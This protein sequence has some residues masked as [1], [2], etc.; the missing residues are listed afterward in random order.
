MKKVFSIV[1]ACI[2]PF[3]CIIPFSAFAAASTE[4]DADFTLEEFESLEHTYDDGIQLYA[5]G[6]I[7]DHSL[8]IAKSG[9][10]LLITGLTKGTS[11][12]KKAGFTK[13][14]IERKKVSESS[15]S[16]YKTYSDLYA[17]SYKYTL[18]KS[19]AVDA[20]Y[21]YRVTATHYAKK[22]LFSTQKIDATTGSLTF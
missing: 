1:I 6:L 12:V 3:I 21:Q 7:T 22:S 11:E 8:G 16:K 10:K 14:V 2:M 19:V 4:D 5:T 17:D 9:T 20:G 15:W 18:T 13:V